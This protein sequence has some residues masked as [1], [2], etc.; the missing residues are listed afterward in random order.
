MIGDL[1]AQLMMG[2]ADDRRAASLLADGEAMLRGALSA[3]RELE[4]SGYQEMADALTDHLLE[5][6]R[7]I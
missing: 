3:I 5:A 4:D 1:M 6:L 2:D 7:P